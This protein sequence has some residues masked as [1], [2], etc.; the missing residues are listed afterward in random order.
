MPCYLI[1]SP[2]T[3]ILT[4]HKTSAIKFINLYDSIEGF[5]A[6]AYTGCLKMRFMF[7][8]C[9]KKVGITDERVLTVG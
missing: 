3:K 7:V 5:F 1:E 2:D 6:K 9:S 8:G 4:K